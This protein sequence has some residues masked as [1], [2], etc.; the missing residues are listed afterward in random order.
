MVPNLLGDRYEVGRLLGTGAI[1]EV[2][3][4]WDRLHGRRVEIKVLLDAYAG[5]ELALARFRGEA[6]VAARLRHPNV[7]RVEDAE[8]DD[9]VHFVVL[10]A[11]DGPSLAERLDDGTPLGWRAVTA[12]G[13]AVCS[14]LEHAHD[15]G[16]VHGRLTSG[17]VLLGTD[18]TVKTGG[19]GAGAQAAA[20]LGAAP[21]ADAR[22][23]AP[24]LARGGRPDERSDVYALGCC[25]YEAA[26]GQ[27][28]FD[29]ESAAQ[30]AVRHV[31]EDPVPPQRR[32]PELPADL[33]EV[34]LRALAKRPGDRPQTAP[35][36]REE[37]QRVLGLDTGS[38]P[39]AAAAAGVAPEVAAGVAAGA[40]GAAAAG[41]D[42]FAE[43]PSS[44][45][46]FGVDDAPASTVVVGWAEPEAEPSPRR[47][48]RR[49]LIP[50]GL[51]LATFGVASAI[52]ATLARNAVPPTS[53]P[54]VEQQAVGAPQSDPGM[55]LSPDVTAGT[56]TTGV[57]VT[58]ATATTART[59]TTG[60]GATTTTRRPA[61]TRPVGRTTTT[62]P[63]T[64][65]EPPV[66]KTTT[67]TL[68]DPDPSIPSIIA[69]PGH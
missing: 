41:R 6:R 45:D 38:Q 51:V 3:E 23:L 11:V 10:E 28:P 33:G 44:D 26:T 7:I 40:A 50:I 47:R 22:Y 55:A 58:A 66:E 8:Q 46:L 36:L 18:G 62:R 64:T 59:A 24:E 29:G 31:S 14:A 56:S 37:L 21:A 34:I 49:W 67:T 12:I 65:T 35:A 13:A 15:L 27:V 52:G 57:R 1:S 42:P 17:C 68:L 20:G 9:G 63:T 25:L 69:P 48:R 53:R 16:V 32:N 30:I 5:D 43:D 2:Y 19:F 39:A 60:K 61:T 4:G 54:P